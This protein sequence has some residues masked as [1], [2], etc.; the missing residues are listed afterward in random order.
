QAPPS[1]AEAP[2][3]TSVEA[4]VDAPVL[5]SNGVSKPYLSAEDEDAATA[6]AVAP[7]VQEADESAPA[8]SLTAASDTDIQPSQE[9]ADAP[10]TGQE[11]QQ[12][13]SSQ[14]QPEAQPASEQ[15]SDQVTAESQAISLDTWVYD[16]GEETSRES[17]LRE[18]VSVWDISID[19]GTEPC[20]EIAAYGLR[21]LKMHGSWAMINEINRPVILKLHLGD[22]RP[23]YL[24]LLGREGDSVVIRFD[25]AIYHFPSE[26]LSARWFGEF[27]LIWQEPPTGF[28][29][30]M[31]PGDRGAQIEWLRDRLN[32]INGAEIPP[33]NG[34]DLFDERLAEAVRLFQASKHLT[35]D[36]MVGMQTIIRLNSASPSDSGP[37]LRARG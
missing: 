18:L 15:A 1:A 16:H 25:A 13:V 9:A 21:C 20:G 8:G 6:E 33:E 19:P 30:A 24:T 4:P 22:Q 35:P 10:V 31:R 27:E 37:R 11:L 7:A 17:A 26:E 2:V 28:R 12:P 3:E 5:I 34:E 32:E 23:H 36:A 14:Q 29:Y